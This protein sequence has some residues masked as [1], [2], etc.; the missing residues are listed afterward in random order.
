MYSE[1]ITLILCAGLIMSS[2]LGLS[3]KKVSTTLISLFY[4]SILLGIILTVFGD[5]LLGLLHM[6][7]YAGALSV[8]L[9]SV[10]LITGQSDL[11]LNS[12]NLIKIV[13][14]ILIAFTALASVFV[15]SSSGNVSVFPQ[16]I[17]L[18]LLSFL[19]Q[20]RPWDLLIIIMLFMSSMLVLANL[21]SKGD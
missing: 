1:I 9:L 13:G 21:F 16:D 18:Q 8:M 19:W 14:G 3:S 10:I 7:T 11:S 15:F 17:S 4:S 5:A 6:V 20:F 12:G 2:V